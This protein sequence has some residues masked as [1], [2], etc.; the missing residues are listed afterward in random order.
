MCVLS[1]C[2]GVYYLKCVDTSADTLITLNT[3]FNR[4]FLGI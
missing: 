2:P 4:L 3:L 1:V